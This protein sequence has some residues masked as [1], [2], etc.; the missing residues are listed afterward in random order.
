[1]WKL[2]LLIHLK[3]KKLKRF[4][5]SMKNKKKDAKDRIQT[6]FENIQEKRREEKITNDPKYENFNEDLGIE[7]LIDKKFE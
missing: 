5:K 3:D 2:S 7:N 6:M 4:K 1:M